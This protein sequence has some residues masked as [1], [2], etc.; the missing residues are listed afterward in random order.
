MI[1]ADG[2]LETSNSKESSPALVLACEKVPCAK[3][4]VPAFG[5][6]SLGSTLFDYVP[7]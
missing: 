2:T 1:T 4:D 3:K 5:D 6:F 7:I